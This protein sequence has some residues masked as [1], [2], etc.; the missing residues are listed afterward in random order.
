[1]HYYELKP[2]DN[3]FH[4]VVVD[5]THRC[6]MECANCYIPN[7]EISDMDVDHLIETIKKFP[8]RTEIR[9][10]GGEPTLRVDLPEIIKRVRMSGHRPTM[11]TNGLKLSHKSYVEKLYKAGLKVLNISMNGF[12]DDN[13][14]KV[15][16]NM[17]C[18]EKKMM[19][20]QNCLERGMLLNINCII[21]KG[22]NDHIPKRIFDFFSKNNWRG[23]LR[24]RNVGQL[25]R[26]AATKEESYKF[27]ELIEHI[28]EQVGK[29]PDYIHQFHSVD[30]Y[31]EEMNVLFPIE[32]NKKSKIWIKITD[33]SPGSGE[34]IPDP[35][36][37]RR[38]RITQNFTVAPFF[39]HVKKNEFGY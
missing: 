10:M 1:M 5:V 29:S 25:G 37:K 7:R 28:G 9:L 33:W 30:G 16:D 23:I 32:E 19:A 11:L 2:E 4:S 34:N 27:E 31:S 15:L 36:S 3:H 17:A 12:D 18:A 14:Y 38:G 13:V 20:L 21:M 8:K 22:V 26:H 39:E 24:F 6:N 35:G